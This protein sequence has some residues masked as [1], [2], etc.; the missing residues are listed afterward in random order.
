MAD[1]YQ[2]QINKLPKPSNVTQSPQKDM[3]EW[4]SSNQDENGLLA[5][6]MR[7]HFKGDDAVEFSKLKMQCVTCNHDI[8]DRCGQHRDL[9]KESL[10]MKGDKMYLYSCTNCDFMAHS[11]N[12]FSKHI[13]EV[14]HVIA[15]KRTSENF[16]DGHCRYTADMRFDANGRDVYFMPKFI[17]FDNNSIGLWPD[18]DELSELADVISMSSEAGSLHGPSVGTSTHDTRETCSNM[19]DFLFEEKCRDKGKTCEAKQQRY[20]AEAENVAPGLIQMYYDGPERDECIR[21]IEGIVKKYDKLF[22]KSNYDIDRFKHTVHVPKRKNLP[23][24][25]FPPRTLHPSKYDVAAEIA[26]KLVKHNVLSRGLSSTASPAVWVT[27]HAPDKPGGG[28]ERLETVAKNLRLAVDYRQANLGVRPLACAAPSANQIIQMLAGKRFVTILDISHAYWNVAVDERSAMYF[29]VQMMGEIFWMNRLGMG[30]MNSGP[31]LSHC[32]AHTLRKC[33]KFSAAYADNIMIASTRLNEHMG[34]VDA[35]FERLHAHG[36]KL[37]HNKVHYCIHDKNLK[38]LGFQFNLANQTVEPDRSKIESIL[39]LDRPDD[40]KSVRR[41]LGSIQ[42][43]ATFIPWLQHVMKP[44]SDT[45][46]GNPD[47]IVW[48]EKCE[49]AW[50]H[51]KVLLTSELILKMPDFTLNEFHLVS[52]ASGKALAS[53]LMQWKDDGWNIIG[54]HSKKLNETEQRYYQLELELFSILEGLRHWNDMLAYSKVKIH[55][56]CRALLFL[57]LCGQVSP[58]LARWLVYLNSFDHQYVFESSTSPLIKLVDFMTRTAPQGT[59]RVTETKN[60]KIEALKA[61]PDVDPELLQS[62]DAWS[63]DEIWQII[64]KHIDDNKDVIDQTAVR[65]II[66]MK[67]KKLGDPPSKPGEG[68]ANLAVMEARTDCDLGPACPINA[69]DDKK[70]A[71]PVGNACLFADSQLKCAYADQVHPDLFHT[72][73]AKDKVIPKTPALNLLRLECPN[74]NVSTIHRAQRIDPRSALIIRN[75]EAAESGEFGS[76]KLEG[77]LLYK[78]KNIAGKLYQ[79]LVIPGYHIY[80]V[81]SLMHRAPYVGHGG[82]K[83]LYQ[84]A[85]RRFYSPQLREICQE[86]HRTCTVCMTYKPITKIYRKTM[87]RPI[88]ADQPGQIYHLDS[89]HVSHNPFK[90]E[91]DK[92]MQFITCTDSFTKYAIAWAAPLR[93]SRDEL[94]NDILGRVIAPFGVPLGIVTDNEFRDVFTTEFCTALRIRKLEIAPRASQANLAERIHRALLT[95]IRT[96]RMQ[97]NEKAIHW[98]ALL[99]FAVLAWNHSPNAEGVTPAETFLGRTQKAPWAC[100]VN[101]EMSLKDYT[102]GV[103]KL[104]QAQ[105]L[106]AQMVGAAKHYK[107]Q[108]E[109]KTRNAG[110]NSSFPPGTY[111]MRKAHYTNPHYMK[112][113]ERCR[114]VYVVTHEM[115]TAVDAVPVSQAVQDEAEIEQQV[116]APD[117]RKY[118][119]KPKRIDKKEIKRVDALTFYSYPLAKQFSDLF[120]EPYKYNCEYVIQ[121]DEGDVAK[122]EPEKLEQPAEIS[123]LQAPLTVHEKVSQWRE[124]GQA[125]PRT[126]RGR[127]VRKPDRLSY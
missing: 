75:C 100:F 124:H 12:E 81:V 50:C 93:Y 32:V 68:K 54:N 19:S 23:S 83:R 104:M 119:Y 58:K 21:T 5:Q 66:E 95:G 126:K 80:D 61:L 18:V 72:C 99:S 92:N 101:L 86:I 114:G 90:G 67:V 125:L 60:Q 109:S 120:L 78:L 98:D 33:K 24:F 73:L 3:A 30:A 44:V 111:I 48:T 14:H 63:P 55:T 53:Q 40:P 113:R 71:E 42:F 110:L 107:M 94:M 7:K 38:F 97:V 91:S 8:L 102:P 35:V 15:G 6:I 46:K 70:T 77:E 39:K 41:L 49:E 31:I 117:A 103:T 2:R 37:K 108:L 16:H 57:R 85:R 62:K 13:Q 45:L 43:Y 9:L 116:G 88:K 121:M 105:M 112:L 65:K 11:W 76:Y 84:L 64:D 79:V 52:D 4:L 29:S 27:K 74:M 59:D 20:S 89:C 36:W 10:N 22:A 17:D 127:Q 118:I 123:Q 34:H 115:P 51:L 122:S 106:V 47:K 56:D 25:S 96:S 1:F 26:R 69:Q 82:G 87:L 28:G